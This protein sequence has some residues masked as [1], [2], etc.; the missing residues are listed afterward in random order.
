MVIRRLLDGERFNHDGPA[1]SSTDA[2]CE[3]RPIQA[4]LPILVGGSGPAQDA[5]HRGRAR[6]RVEH[7]RDAR[8]R[9]RDD[10]GVARPCRRRRSRPRDARDDHQL[11]DHRA[12]PG[13]RCADPLRR[14]DGTTGRR[15]PAT[16]R[17]SSDRP[18]RSP[19]PSARTGRAASRR[20][21]CACPRHTTRRPSTGWPRSPRSS[22][23]EGRRPSPVGRGGAKLAAGLQAVLPAGDLTVIVNTGD[24]TERHGLLVMPD[25][26]AVLYMLGGRVRRRA[27]LGRRRRDMDGHG[28][29]GGR[30]AR[31]A[32]SASAIATWRRTSPVR[33]RLRAGEPLTDAVRA[34]QT[35]VGLATPI[36]P[37]T[38]A[39]VRTRSPHGRG[40]A[41]L[42]GVLRPP[43]PGAGRP[44][45][46]LRR[47]RCGARR[48]PP[49]W[50][51]S[52]PPTPSSS[53]RP[54]RSCRSGRSWRSPACATH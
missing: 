10:R 1:T 32:G 15:T 38:D 43:P 7:V 50:P 31:T 4:H 11:P 37:M 6:R 44:R 12:R 30:T 23:R 9:R 20:S 42:P 35:A 14:A 52:T 2:L 45:G 24:D 49:C 27:R 22:G 25:H 5:A 54:T 47:D 21:S 41:G 40:L 28:R 8:G 17:S 34:L 19:M 33:A 46:R 39:P 48:R 51:R 29:P 18:S 26:D 36:L 53:A 13:G 3:P 16:G